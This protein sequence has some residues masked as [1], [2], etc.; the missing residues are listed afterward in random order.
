MGKSELIKRLQNPYDKDRERVSETIPEGFPK[1]GHHTCIVAQTMGG[2]SFLTKYLLAEV[3]PGIFH[4]IFVFCPNKKENYHVFDIPK[5]NIINE[6]DMDDIQS[7]FEDIGEEFMKSKG[8]IHTL[9]IFD[10]CCERLKKFGKPFTEIL[11]TARHFSISIW[12]SEQYLKF[13]TPGLRTNCIAFF[14]FPN[15]SDEFIDTL[16]ESTMGRKKLREYIDIAR[17]EN[18]SSSNPHGC[19]Y[20]NRTQFRKVYYV[21]THDEHIELCPIE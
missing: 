18:E 17:D 20:W 5:D 16:G 6:F 19:I 2:K 14:I 12:M 1:L 15:L 4:Q 13:L 11:C 7:L 9:W 8:K 21:D 3:Y 10:D